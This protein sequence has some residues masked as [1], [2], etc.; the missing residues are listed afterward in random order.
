MFCASSGKRPWEAG[1]RTE[2]A[3]L[4]SEATKEAPWEAG[5]QTEGVNA[6]AS[7]VTKDAPREAGGW[8]EGVELVVLGTVGRVHSSTM[9]LLPTMRN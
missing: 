8:T 9:A 3:A 2:G 5:S 6:L 1:G 7:E 4:A